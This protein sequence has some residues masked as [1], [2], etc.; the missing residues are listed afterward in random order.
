MDEV[1]LRIIA[2]GKAVELAV[3]FGAPEICVISVAEAYYKF[4][5]EGPT[6]DDE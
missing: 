5:L 4:L 3:G 1:Q 2:L 6:N